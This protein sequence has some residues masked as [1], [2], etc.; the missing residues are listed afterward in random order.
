LATLPGIDANF[1]D[2]L[3][4]ALE[5]AYTASSVPI[6]ALIITNPNNPLAVCYSKDLLV[7]CLKFCEKYQLH[8]ISDEIYALSVFKNPEIVEPTPF[9][10]ILSLDLEHV[11]VDPSRVHMV[12][13]MSKDF[14]QS[15]IRMVR[16]SIRPLPA[17]AK[18]LG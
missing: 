6:K 2:E 8:F 11:G 12:W 15:G 4:S 5:E 14:G 18:F 9:T 16:Y 17:H 1:T 3:I 7:K 13:S 10:S